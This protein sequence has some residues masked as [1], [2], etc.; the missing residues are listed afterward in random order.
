MS[1]LLVFSYSVLQC[2]FG[3]LTTFPGRAVLCYPSN[4]SQQMAGKNWSSLNIIHSS[5]GVAFLC[6]IYFLSQSQILSICF[7]SLLSG[8][9]GPLPF[10]PDIF[11]LSAISPNSHLS[12]SSCRQ[13]SPSLPTPF[14]KALFIS[15]TTAAPCMSFELAARVCVVVWV[16][17]NWL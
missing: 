11:F 4:P 14:Q 7:I 9:P 3:L 2:L 6:C 13:P 5:V 15:M 17:P 8:L 12:S 1:L 10:S 16:C